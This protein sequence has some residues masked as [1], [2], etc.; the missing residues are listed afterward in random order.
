MRMSIKLD[1][2]NVTLTWDDG[3]PPFQLQKCDALNDSPNWYLVG[4]PTMATSASQPVI[5]EQ[6]YFRVQEQVPLLTASWTE[7]AHVILTWIAPDLA[8]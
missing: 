6:G 7:D 3:Q 2:G 5:G 1:G 4:N 8:G